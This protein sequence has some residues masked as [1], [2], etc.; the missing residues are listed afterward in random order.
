MSRLQA[1]ARRI[2]LVIFDVDG[3]LTDG[4]LTY[5][6][7]GEELK[8]FHVRDGHGIKQL[9][10]N[11]IEVAVISGRH[12]HSVTR[13]MTELGVTRVYQG[14]DDKIPVFENLLKE[15]GLS[16]DQAAYVGDD[17]PDLPV[18]RRV[19]LPVAVANAHPALD[20]ASL[21]RTHSPGG[22]GAAR[23]VT[24]LILAAQAATDQE[25][26]GE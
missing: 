13:R 18:M 17:A 9:L 3:V 7:A 2:R 4:K 6:N 22:A 1:A 10:A 20:D 11:G 25:R 24:D 16:A 19:G 23:E 8:T 21:W 15:T 5:S 14:C 26:A 12:S